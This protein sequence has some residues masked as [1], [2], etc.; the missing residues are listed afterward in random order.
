MVKSQSAMKANS[1]GATG[2]LKGSFG[3]VDHHP[4]LVEV[5]QFVIQ[6]YGPIQGVKVLDIVAPA[7]PHAL[8]FLRDDA[9]AGG[10]HQPV[11]VDRCP[12]W[13]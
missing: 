13:S 10:H 3:D 2:H 6:G 4:A 1:R 11:V 12:A 8:D 7:G 5:L 9:A